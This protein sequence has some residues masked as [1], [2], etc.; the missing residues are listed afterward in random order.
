MNGALLEHRTCQTPYRRN[1][2]CSA[3][4]W[5]ATGKIS[6]VD[7]GSFPC[8]LPA[9]GASKQEMGGVPMDRELLTS[10]P[11]MGRHGTRWTMPSQALR[12]RRSS[13][14]L[15]MLAAITAITGLA[16]WDSRHE[17]E[18]I[19]RDL[20]AEQSVVAAIVARDLGARLA[21]LQRPGVAVDAA[22]LL[23]D[24]QSLEQPGTFRIFLA[25]PGERALL[26][27]D[28]ARVSS[29]PLRDALDAG[30]ATVRLNR[31]QAAEVGLLARTAMAGLAH[32]DAGPLGR[33]GVVAL[34]TAA[35]QRDR[36]TRA[37]WRLVLGVTV[38]S[39][40]VLAFGGLALQNQR[41]E[42][43]AQREL[44]VAAVERERDEKLARA[45]RLATM[46]TFAMGVVHEVS[47]PLGVIVGRAEQLQARA[48]SDER[49]A[50]AAQA[51]TAQVDR[52]Q[53]IIR[54]F[55]DMARGGRPVLSSAGAGD[56]IESAAASVRHRFAKANV[57]LTTAAP[58]DAPVIQCDRPLLE[59]A[60][61]NLLLNACDA[62][63]AGGH[64]ELAV[65]SD[66]ERVAF[67]VTDDGVG[68]P[69]ED[70][71]RA[72]D[73]F[74]TTKPAGRGSGLGLAI[75]SEIAK[76]HRGDLSIA[77]HGRRGTR[78]RLEISCLLGLSR[79]GTPEAR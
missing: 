57:S 78:A 60:I 63:T 14:V 36:E 54:R 16:W 41:R 45:E 39:G 75:A 42:L 62:C 76:S 12:W 15:W 7:Q 38:A 21:A 52:I 22:D 66:A 28:G 10:P 29:A 71:A 34:A 32:V 37:F 18:A 33:W 74:F 48:G 56:L 9:C 46:G 17:S 8:S 27:A 23:G 44:A 24:P 49:S 2:R 1:P 35:R 40:L 19:F 61:V 79:R 3:V 11:T 50:H 47:T 69:P 67:V 68:I 73:P 58:P 4:A 59:Q 51:I 31:P 65:R 55:L 72:T 77:P 20:G 26:A 6:G 64:V 70:A 30:A 53:V 13:L 5:P 25:P 43:Q